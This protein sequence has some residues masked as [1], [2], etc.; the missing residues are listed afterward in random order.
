MVWEILHKR[1]TWNKQ[2]MPINLQF[3]IVNYFPLKYIQEIY[4]FMMLF[5]PSKIYI[6]SKE[7]VLHKL[8]TWNKQIMLNNLQLYS[9]YFF[10][11]RYRG[12][13][14]KQFCRVYIFPSKRY[15]MNIPIPQSPHVII[16]C[17]IYI[18]NES[19]LCVAKWCNDGFN[20]QRG[21]FASV[22]WING[23][24]NNNNLFFKLWLS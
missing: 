18:I 9:L 19:S 22:S 13:N 15:I 3:G 20:I 11:I 7:I 16:L 1:I 2:I 4:N 8:I 12:N 17:Q 21:K 23:N 5:F 24:N 14:A 6:Y 10:P